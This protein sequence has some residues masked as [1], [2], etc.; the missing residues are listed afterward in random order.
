MHNEQGG[1]IGWTCTAFLMV[2][3]MVTPQDWSYIMASITAGATA[4]FYIARTV[5]II[6]KKS[7]NESK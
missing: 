4:V 3:N 5:E 6:R 2:V 1:I 7:D